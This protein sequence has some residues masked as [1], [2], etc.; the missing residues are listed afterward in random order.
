MNFIQTLEF[1][2]FVG[3]VINDLL[4][5]L[6][7]FRASFEASEGT[8]HRARGVAFC[9]LLNQAADSTLRKVVGSR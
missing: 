4:R 5:Q 7:E 9:W 2:R 1:D 6:H 3:I 8:P